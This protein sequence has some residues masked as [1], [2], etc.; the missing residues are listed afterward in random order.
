MSPIL[1]SPLPGLSLLSGVIDSLL[2]AVTSHKRC[3]KAEPG[4]PGKDLII[5]VQK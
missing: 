4:R 3:R 5:N 1:V 2:T